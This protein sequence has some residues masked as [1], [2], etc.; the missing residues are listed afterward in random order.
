MKMLDL[1]SVSRE[2]LHY[3]T[4]CNRDGKAVMD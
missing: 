4:L 3:S 2:I 1:T